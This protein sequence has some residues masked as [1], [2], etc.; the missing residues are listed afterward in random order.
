L[1]SL[2]ETHSNIQSSQRE[3]LQVRQISAHDLIGVTLINSSFPFVVA[4]VCPPLLFE[5]SAV[6]SWRRE[7][8]G[9][10]P[11]MGNKKPLKTEGQKAFI[12]SS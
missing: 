7:G 3:S 11:G 6:F 1:A 9:K 8:M 12:C 2:H 4:T 10:Q 5:L